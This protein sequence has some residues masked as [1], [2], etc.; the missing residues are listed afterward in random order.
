M[1]DEK[2]KAL[3]E[4]VGGYSEPTIWDY[5]SEGLTR[6]FDKKALKPLLMGMLSNALH[7]GIDRVMKQSSTNFS[8]P[9]VPTIPQMVVDY[10]QMFTNGIQ[11]I[12]LPGSTDTP[13]NVYTMTD[14]ESAYRVK[15]AIEAQIQLRGFIDIPTANYIAD[16][17]DSADFV[18]EDFGWTDISSARIEMYGSG[19]KCVLI[20]PQPVVIKH[21][22]NAK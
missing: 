17:P 11:Q 12:Q 3:I 21:L 15:A 22:K 14:T 5:I 18:D 20:L 19:S 16:K 7:G 1:I 4:H 13:K 10:R 6:F 2:D 8:V 9:A